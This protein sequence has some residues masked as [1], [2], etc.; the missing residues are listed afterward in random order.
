[1]NSNALECINPTYSERQK[2]NETNVQKTTPKK[3][4]WKE[5]T[6]KKNVSVDEEFTIQNGVDVQKIWKVV[7]DLQTLVKKT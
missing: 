3:P 4:L 1:M 2:Q 5:Q 6:D 7:E